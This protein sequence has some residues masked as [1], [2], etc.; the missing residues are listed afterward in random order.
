MEIDEDKIF[1]D[2]SDHCL[3]KLNLEVSQENL[4]ITKNREIIEYFNVKDDQKDAFL[5]EFLDSVGN[6]KVENMN[7]EKFDDILGGCAE[8]TLKKRFIKRFKENNKP[9]AV[10]FTTKMKD[11]I[12]LH[13]Q[14]NRLVRNASNNEDKATFKILYDEQRRKTS[15]LIKEG[16]S[17]YEIKI[18]ERL[19]QQNNSTD[20]W[21]DIN[22]LRRREE[23]KK[24]KAIYDD[25]G[26]PMEKD[27][28]GEVV[29]NYWRGIYQPDEN[30]I[31]IAWNEDKKENYNVELEEENKI[32]IEFAKPVPD[33]IR[34]QYRAVREMMQRIGLERPEDNLLNRE[35]KEGYV[36]PRGTSKNQGTFRYGW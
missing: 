19:K 1:Y 8:R 11:S 21:K 18:T 25:E 33:E 4:S 5:T 17:N 32:K 13:R 36:E 29:C 26:K 6:E 23:D 12:K 20:M 24:D 30:K 15:M 28:I 3:I 22:K 35:S 16:I 9:E 31:H 34:Y 2:L 10:W 27:K 14:Y 7:M